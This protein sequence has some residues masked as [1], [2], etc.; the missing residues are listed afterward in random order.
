MCS[1]AGARIAAEVVGRAASLTGDRFVVHP[2]SRRRSRRLPRPALLG[3]RSPRGSFPPA[4]RMRLAA[5]R[6]RVGVARARNAHRDAR[7]L[8]LVELVEPTTFAR[9]MPNAGSRP[10]RYAGSRTRV[11]ARRLVRAQTSQPRSP[12]SSDAR[13]ERL[14]TEALGVGEGPVASPVI[15]PHL[16]DAERAAKGR[17]AREAVPR[18]SHG[19]FTAAADRE[20]VRILEEQG[21]SRVAELLPIR[22]G[23]MLAS[24]FTFYRGAAAVMAADLSTTPRTS[25]KVQLCGDAH[26]A[27]FGGF[28]SPERTLVFDI[29][30]FDETLPGPFEWDV[31]RLAASFE[32]AGRDRNFS[33]A[34]RRTAVLARNPLL[35]R[36]DAQLR[37]DGSARGLVLP[38]RRRRTRGAISDPRS[39][40]RERRPPG[41]WW[42]RRGRRTACGRWGS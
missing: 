27:N 41:R 37:A 38:P 21:I 25:L 33:V 31:K 3:C 12:S 19:A 35:P 28:A 9:F 22:Y 2:L 40:R 5:T 4:R 10:A 32:V 18:S 42:R 39:T 24:A 14:M 13:R 7:R 29:N 16:T 6:P 26:L 11:D 34:D 1:L 36:G 23:R 30:D 8:E 17:A 20:P 15:V